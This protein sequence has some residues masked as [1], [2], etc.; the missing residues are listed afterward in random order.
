MSVSCTPGPY[1]EHPRW[2]PEGVGSRFRSRRPRTWRR[3][4]TRPTSCGSFGPGLQA[5]APGGERDRPDREGPRASMSRAE[6][7]RGRRTAAESPSSGRAARGRGSRWRARR[8]RRDPRDSST[9]ERYRCGV[10]AG[11]SALA[12][13]TNDEGSSGAPECGTVWRLTPERKLSASPRP[14]PSPA[15]V[16]SLVSG[17]STVVFQRSWYGTRYWR[18]S[19]LCPPSQCPALRPAAYSWADCSRLF[20]YVN[21]LEPAGC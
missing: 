11:W 6:P 13:T 15:I 10:V 7:G 8:R 17:R 21:P 4:R 3:T 5:P 19:G 12:V 9:S 2:S 1:A 14:E 18:R 16:S 20:E